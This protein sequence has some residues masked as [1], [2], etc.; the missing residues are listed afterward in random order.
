VD[1]VSVSQGDIILVEQQASGLQNGVYIVENPGS[2]GS[3]YVLRR[4]PL[5]DTGEKV[6]GIWIHVAAGTAN[7]NKMYVNSNT[8]AITMGTTALNFASDATTLATTP[9]RYNVAVG[10]SKSIVSHGSFGMTSETGTA[11]LLYPA[12]GQSVNINGVANFGT[13]IAN[14]GGTIMTPLVQT[15]GTTLGSGQTVVIA[16]G[17]SITLTI[18]A[19]ASH[20]GRFYWIKNMNATDLTLA[21]SSTDT[22]DNGATT[23]TLTSGQW[24]ALIADTAPATDVWRTLAFG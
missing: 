2:G 19:A 12:S 1:G 16:N 21:R 11:L 15:S 9:I 5:E 13:A 3:A 20:A 18:P 22:F 4:H 7:T 14:Q 10:F 8:G 6:R 23:L 17:S 24:I